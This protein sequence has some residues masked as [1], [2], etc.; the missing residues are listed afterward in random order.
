MV[1]ATFGRRTIRRRSFLR[2]LRRQLQLRDAEEQYPITQLVK[3][4]PAYCSRNLFNVDFISKL[5]TRRDSL[6]VPLLHPIWLHQ[7]QMAPV[8]PDFSLLRFSLRTNIFFSYKSKTYFSYGI[9]AVFTFV[10][11]S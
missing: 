6:S 11:A 10:L 4:H 1:L 9:I 8:V 5:E 3:I 2:L 7:L